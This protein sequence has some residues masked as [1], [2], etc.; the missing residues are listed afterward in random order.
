M[1]LA[2]MLSLYSEGITLAQTCRTILE[3]ASQQIN[4]ISHISNTDA[5][6]EAFNTAGSSPMA[7]DDIPF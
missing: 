6:G 1:P 3:N 4:E 5:L 7:A 2:E